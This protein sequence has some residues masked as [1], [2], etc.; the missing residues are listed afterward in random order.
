MDSEKILIVYSADGCTYILIHVITVFMS[1]I[2]KANKN[3]K[4]SLNMQ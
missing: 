3:H 4:H 2:F 1:F